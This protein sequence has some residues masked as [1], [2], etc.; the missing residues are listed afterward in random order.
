MIIY[1]YMDVRTC[2]CVCVICS[3]IRLKG[4]HLIVRLHLDYLQK[5]KQINNKIITFKSK[6]TQTKLHI[7]ILRVYTHTIAGRWTEC[8]YS[9][10]EGSAGN[11]QPYSYYRPA[12]ACP[13]NTPPDGNPPTLASNSRQQSDRWRRLQKLRS[14]HIRYSSYCTESYYCACKNDRNTVKFHPP[15]IRSLWTVLAIGY[16]D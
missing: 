2:A 14:V 3:G 10:S 4:K 9:V 15:Y 16:V 13:D 1:I 7:P 8:S 6:I 5:Q 12:V 11:Y